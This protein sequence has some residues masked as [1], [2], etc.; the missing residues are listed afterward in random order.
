MAWTTATFRQ[1]ELAQNTMLYTNFGSVSIFDAVE[2]PGKDTDDIRLVALVALLK[3]KVLFY[4]EALET[5]TTIAGP[6]VPLEILDSIRLYIP[7]SSIV[8]SNHELLR[9][10]DHS[11]TARTIRQQ[12]P[13][14]YKRIV[15]IRIALKR[16]SKPEAS[17]GIGVQQAELDIQFSDRCWIAVPGT[18]D[19]LNKLQNDIERNGE[20]PVSTEHRE[21]EQLGI[22]KPI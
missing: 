8:T 21:E 9:R 6:K 16:V 17:E 18:S 14:L 19:Y 10:N 22:H 7:A 3:L 12:I 15:E 2:F 20:L 1:T 4:L 13:L 5:T 11:A